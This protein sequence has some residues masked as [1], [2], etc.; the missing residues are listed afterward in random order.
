MD[1]YFRALELKDEITINK[2]RRIREYEVL[3]KSPKRFISLERE[4]K[5]VEDLIMKDYQDRIYVAICEKET[6]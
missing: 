3:I 5:W 6:S 1:I 4:K 2:M